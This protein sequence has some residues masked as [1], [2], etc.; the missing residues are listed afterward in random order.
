MSADN[1]PDENDTPHT[2]SEELVI[3]LMEERLEIDKQQFVQSQFHVERKTESKQVEINESLISRQAEVKHVPIGKY[4]DIIPT[5]RDEAG[6]KIIPVFEEHIEIVKRIYLK[7]E[8]RIESHEVINE[9][10]SEET[11]KYQTVS[12]KRISTDK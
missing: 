6:V 5:V 1:Y 11:L 3:P 4:V 10:K 8:I 9:F 12:H 7:E 2:K